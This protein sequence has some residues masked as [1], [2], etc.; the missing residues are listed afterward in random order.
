MKYKILLIFLF[1]CSCTSSD[2]LK[3]N[4]SKKSY[5]SKGFA[6]IY[7]NDDFINKIVTTKI[8]NSTLSVSHNLLKKGTTVKII[9]P[10]TKDNLILK[11]SQKT[12]FPEFYN[13]MISQ[14][15]ANE[16]NINTEFP[17]IELLEIKKNKTFIA[18]KATTHNDEKNIS[19]KA[20]VTKVKIDNLSLTKKS[21]IKKNKKFLII[22]GEF[23]SLEAA[24]NLKKRLTQEILN[25]NSN[26][27][28]IN[29]K[30]KNKVELLSGPYKSINYLKK[31]YIK[32]KQ[33]GFEDL[34]IK[35][36]E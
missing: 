25:F 3:K 27:L 12:K 4:I 24:V 31:D 18:K 9:N 34:D 10:E 20:P 2:Y 35:I 23:Y 13:V 21:I 26:K 19:N 30:N 14:Q 16:L 5:S 33:F 7:N 15:V 32:I 28:S 1:L 11:L 29:T 6:Y 17:Y 36:Y 22:I 8:D